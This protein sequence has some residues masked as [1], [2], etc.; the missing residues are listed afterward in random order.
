MALPN[1][2]VIKA[3]IESLYAAFTA[4]KTAQGCRSAVQTLN[5][6][7]FRLNYLYQINTVPVTDNA[8]KVIIAMLND[9]AGLIALILDDLTVTDVADADL[10]EFYISGGELYAGLGNVPAAVGDIFKVAGT[11]DTLDNALAGAKGSAVAD[12]DVFIVTDISTEALVYLGAAGSLPTGALASVLG[13]AAV[14]GDIFVI[15]STNDTADNALVAAKG[16]SIA[17]GDV[18]GVQDGADAGPMISF[19][20]NSDRAFDYDGESTSDFG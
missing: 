14:V 13:R 1:P 16:S 10:G 2:S 18:F 12:E 19:L 11:G 15:T 7:Q 6:M 9:S 3:A 17:I 5:E 8:D 20:G 4:D